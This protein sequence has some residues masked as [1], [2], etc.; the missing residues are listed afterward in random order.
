[1]PAPAVIKTV[2]VA[3][4]RERGMSPSSRACLSRFSDAGSVRSASL[5]S[6]ILH[7]VTLVQ[8]G[9]I[10]DVA[11]DL[12]KKKDGKQPAYRVYDVHFSMDIPM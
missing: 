11:A 7:S 10:P 5:S 6:A 2:K 3:T 8:A 1:M 9:I 4:S 12:E